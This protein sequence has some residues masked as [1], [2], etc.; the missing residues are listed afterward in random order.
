M[1]FQIIDSF[2]ENTDVILFVRDIN[3]EYAKIIVE[4]YKPYFYIHRNGKNKENLYSIG[5]NDFKYKDIDGRPQFKIEEKRGL[6]PFDHYREDKEI[7]FKLIFNSLKDYKLCLRKTIKCE[8]VE[9]IKCKYEEK[10]PNPD[11]YD[12]DD[13]ISIYPDI[14]VLIYENKI[15][16]LLRFF[17]NKN[18]NPCGW[19]EIP[20]N[21]KNYRNNYYVTYNKLSNSDE[22]SN[23]KFV[24]MAYD[25]ECE[26]SHGDFPLAKK[27]YS[28]LLN[29]IDLKYSKSN[30][31]INEVRCIVNK[32]IDDYLKENCFESENFKNL[33]NKK[34]ELIE[35]IMLFYSKLE[36]ENDKKKLCVKDEEINNF[37]I[38]NFPKIK[39]DRIVQIASCFNLYGEKKCYLKH[40]LTISNDVDNNENELEDVIVVKCKTEKDLLEKWFSLIKSNNPDI[41]TGYN[42]YNFDGEYVFNRCHELGITNK[43]NKPRQKITRYNKEGIE[44]EIFNRT[45]NISKLNPNFGLIKCNLIDSVGRIQLD[46]FKYVQKNYGGLSSYKLDDVAAEFITGKIEK[47]NEENTNKIVLSNIDGLHKGNY[48]Q[49][50]IHNRFDVEDY[51]Q[52][53]KKKF[54][55]LNINNNELTICTKLDKDLL[56]KEVSW[57]LGKD[58]VKPIDI[59]NAFKTNGTEKDKL[60]IGKYCVMDTVLCIELMNKLKIISNLMSMANVCYCPLK[61][62]ILR[63]EGIKTL[64]LVS[65][66]CQENNYILPSLVIKEDTNSDYEGAI[67]LDPQPGLYLNKAVSVLDYTSLYP[68]SMI[69]KNLSH[70]MFVKLNDNETINDKIKLLTNKDTGGKFELFKSKIKKEDKWIKHHDAEFGNYIRKIKINDDKEYLFI[71]EGKKGIIPQILQELM[72]HRKQTKKLMKNKNLKQFEYDLLD[73]KQL[74]YKLTANSIYG[75]MG[76]KYSQVFKK[77][78]AEATTAVGR[79][80]LI[81]AKNFVLNEDNYKNYKPNRK[82]IIYK[83]EVVYGD[84]DSIFVKFD[85]RDNFGNKL[86][87]GSI[88][89]DK[90]LLQES[91][92]ISL[93]TENEIGKIELEKPQILE[94]E[95]TF[96][97]FILFGK[98]KYIG[99]KYEIDVNKKPKQT[100]MGVVLKRRDNALILKI[101]YDGIIDNLINKKCVNKAL[102]FLDNELKELKKGINGK[103]DITKL[104]ITKRLSE[105]YKDRTKIAHAVLADRIGIRDPGNKPNTGD[106]IQFVYIE[107]TKQNKNDKILQGDK[108]E[109]PE[110]I[111]ENNINIDYK[112]YITNQLKKPISQIFALVDLSKI[113]NNKDEIKE[114]LELHNKKTNEYELKKK[115]ENNN[116]SLEE[117]IKINEYKKKDYESRIGDL[118]FN[119][120]IPNKIDNVLNS[121]EIQMEIT[122]T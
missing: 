16:P 55:I 59:F 13:K 103:Y 51:Y 98:K 85:C 76:S 89:K 56:E 114:F 14:E 61:Y 64:S 28:L 41:I 31:N 79:E 47:I 118:L 66:K 70:E 44:G 3:N 113:I 42:I 2:Y 83:N 72:L 10:I 107:K 109:T 108:I 1:K 57:C 6:K 22:E 48:I 34:E 40:L 60:K 7:Y 121:S 53:G 65:K 8:N 30:I 18:I 21:S 9:K 58:D 67:V 15:D 68:S 84:T 100:N 112:F 49:I 45:K 82:N 11:S 75:Q 111:L 99:M 52:N 105:E 87:G 106:R 117:K 50:K 73:S 63:G 116:L 86:E 35:E 90:L 81:I 62:I 20:N 17:H 80:Q 77:E 101:I 110:Y 91:I 92:D 88:E 71:Q 78:I 5:S 24:T 104:T 94:Y 74:A 29:K 25:I 46:I 26:S 102:E 32:F 120:Y 69:S 96:Y 37:I 39:G 23:A 27:D 12:E 38:N 19:I 119:K 43:N 33:Q 36:N 54:E 95:K 93:F 97:P 115:K 4:D 122:N